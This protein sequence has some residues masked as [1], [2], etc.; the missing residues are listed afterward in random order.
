MNQQYSSLLL[1]KAVSEF[2][3][4]PGIGK[5][6]AM[7][8]V[9]HL[10][11]Q[12]TATV[13]AFGN[14]VITLKREVKY[15]RVCHNISDTDV[16]QICANTQRDSSTVCVVENIRDVMAVEATQQY[17]GLYHVLG[18][19]ISPMDGVGPGDLQIE[20]LINRVK[21]G[22][23]KE[24]I[25]ALSTTMEG[26]TTNFYLYRKLEKSGVKLSIIA[27]GVS[28]GDELE[29]TDEI[30]LGRSIVNRTAFNGTV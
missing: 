21:D 19:V 26:D 14:S 1:E 4:L 23:V 16:C 2:A 18:G 3:K 9:L 6:T 7:R 10:L 15:C 12:D 17:K 25:L 22:G 24:I 13:E 11:R 8:L 28:I 27:R 29:Y 5:K 20:S 30:T